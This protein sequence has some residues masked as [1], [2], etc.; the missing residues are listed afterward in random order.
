M[1]MAGRDI[2]FVGATNNFQEPD[3]PPEH[4]ADEPRAE[5]R[6]IIVSSRRLLPTGIYPA[7][8][9]IIQARACP[10]HRHYLSGDTQ[11]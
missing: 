7:Y 1:G 4:V 8:E 2:V 10:G 6:P 11:R 9:E 3:A 5:S